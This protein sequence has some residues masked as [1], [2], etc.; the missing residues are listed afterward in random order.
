MLE[1]R[2]ERRFKA[3]V[4]PEY[5]REVTVLFHNEFLKSRVTDASMNG[6]GFLIHGSL[7]SFVKGTSLA[8]YPIGEDHAVAGV[9]TFAKDVGNGHLRIGVQL[10]PVGTAYK[11]YRAELQK[12]TAALS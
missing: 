8:I 3:E 6:F 7:S 11:T 9:I 4:L 5:L 10:K 1:M 2:K 12:I